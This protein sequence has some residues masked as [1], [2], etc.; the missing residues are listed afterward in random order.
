MSFFRTGCAIFALLGLAACVTVPDGPSA[1]ALPGSRKS[2]DQFRSDDASCRQFATGQ[3][4][5]SAAE[6][7]NNSAVASA[8][9]GT[10]VGAAAG[11]AIGGSSGA[12][13][14]GAG[15]GLLAG[16]AAG[17][18]AAQTS[19]YVSQRRYGDAYTQC[20]YAAGHKVAVPGRLAQAYRGP[21][22]WADAP[23]DYRPP[24]HRPP[25]YRPPGYAP[26]PSVTPPDYLPPGSIPPP[27][28]PPPR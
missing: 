12:A 4:G 23:S 10:I 1:S 9:V 13:G 24:D 7:A 20:M 27:N 21:P 5:G 16:S 19:Y 11:A 26:P 25:T 14:V 22:R 3:V 2:F 17:T 6:N 8:V 18:G 15:V 28:A